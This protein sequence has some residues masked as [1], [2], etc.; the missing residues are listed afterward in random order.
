MKLENKNKGPK[1][2]ENYKR[3]KLRENKIINGMRT[4]QKQLFIY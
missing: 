3:K 1:R 2:N 4:K